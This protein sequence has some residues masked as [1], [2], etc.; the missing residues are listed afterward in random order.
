MIPF[1]GC[2]NCQYSCVEGCSH[3]IKG[4]CFECND[5]W[6]YDVESKKCKLECDYCDE[7][8]QGICLKCKETFTLINPKCY[9]IC[10]DGIVTSVFE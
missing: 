1:D 7:C 4:I 2:Y 8:I 6:I 5:P 9:A 10:G 3:C